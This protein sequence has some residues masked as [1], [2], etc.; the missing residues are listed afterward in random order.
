MVLA[1][2]YVNVDS[3]EKAKQVLDKIDAEKPL[4]KYSNYYDFLH[5]YISEGNKTNIKAYADS[6]LGIMENLYT[7]SSL[8]KDKH[9][10]TVIQKERERAALQSTSAMKT[11]LIAAIVV[12]SLTVIT[13]ILYVLHVNKKNAR[14]RMFLEKERNEITLRHEREQSEMKLRH[15]QEFRI[16]ADKLHA[17]ELSSKEAQL[18]T[19]RNFL[20]KKMDIQGKI[21]EFK[22][23]AD[24]HILIDEAD[25]SE[26][27]EFLESIDNLFVSR[28]RTRFPE[29][30][31]SDVRLFM[32][33]RLK[34]PARSLSL[35]YGISEKAIKQ[36]LFLYKTKVGLGDGSTSLRAF[37][38]A[39]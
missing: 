33:L 6:A 21:E 14:R 15:E 22:H 2:A 4:E 28:L 10:S 23:V 11:K 17:K 3:T 8:A 12:L 18:S 32:L 31:V 7:Q 1:G 37:I 34:M 30:T 16:M 5:I 19:M 29:L 38:E 24:K 39:F 25:W 26:I 36:K 20:L 13:F 35:I 9:Y 27:E